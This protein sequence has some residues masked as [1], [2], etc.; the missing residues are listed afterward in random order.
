MGRSRFTTTG[1]LLA[2]AVLSLGGACEA[3]DETDEPAETEQ[4][5]QS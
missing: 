2:A 5:E 1:A 3:L 4:D